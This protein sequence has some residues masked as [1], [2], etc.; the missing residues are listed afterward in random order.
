MARKLHDD[1]VARG[2]IGALDPGLAGLPE[3]QGVRDEPAAEEDAH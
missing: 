3:F 2:S 1:A